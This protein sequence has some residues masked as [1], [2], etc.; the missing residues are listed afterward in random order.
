MREIFSAVS[1]L[2]TWISSPDDGSI[3]LNPALLATQEET[4]TTAERITKSQNGS[5][6]LL[7]IFSI[8]PRNPPVASLLSFCLRLVFVDALM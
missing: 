3:A 4:A 2:S 5:G 8:Q 1:R 6:S 7:P